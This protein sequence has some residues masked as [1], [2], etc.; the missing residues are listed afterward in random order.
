MAP[1]MQRYPKGMRFHPTDLEL[2]DYFLHNKADAEEKGCYS[3]LIYECNDFYGEKEPWVIWDMYGGSTY[4]EGEPLYFY[5]KRIK[6]NSNGKRFA[7]KVGSGTW[8]GEYSK[9]VLAAD[10][11]KTK[12]GTMRNFRYEKGCDSGQNGAWLMHEYESEFDKN[13]E[14]DYVIC[15]LRKNPRKAPAL[16]QPDQR[17]IESTKKSSVND[18]KRKRMKSDDVV[19]HQDHQQ[20]KLKKQLKDDRELIKIEEEERKEE[21]YDEQG[22]SSCTQ[23]PYHLDQDNNT[24]YPDN[25]N[26]YSDYYFPE[27]LG[28]NYDDGVTIDELIGPI[29][30]DSVY[31]KSIPFQD[32]LYHGDDDS[33]N[34]VDYSD[35]GVSQLP[36][37]QH[38][39]VDYLGNI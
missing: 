20:R 28:N 19:D 12:I 5:T 24:Y 14:D 18:K 6:Q 17:D 2:V 15:V 33:F 26:F 25:H 10:D 11:G 16:L 39:T 30:D 38:S 13:G 37:D 31:Y 4:E 3:S 29:S 23:L 21:S 32:Q 8:S 34:F 1:T 27:L 22:C 36:N 7:R 35:G 9:E